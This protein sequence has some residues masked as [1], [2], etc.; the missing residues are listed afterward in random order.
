MTREMEQKERGPWRYLGS[1]IGIGDIAPV[2][3]SVEVPSDRKKEWF[4]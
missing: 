4:S 1:L 3:A 2:I